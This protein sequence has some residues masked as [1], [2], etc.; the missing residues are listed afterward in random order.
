MAVNTNSL[1]GI[2]KASNAKAISPAVT[3]SA[4]GLNPKTPT[5]PQ[6][7]SKT[8][9]AKPTTTSG[10]ANRFAN[11]AATAAKPAAVTKPAATP[12]KTTATKPAATTKT[13]T[14]VT[15][16][17][18]INTTK[19]G[20]VVPAPKATPGE[21]TPPREGWT[22]DEERGGWIPSPADEGTSVVVSPAETILETPSGER[23]VTRQTDAKAALDA[24]IANILGADWIDFQGSRAAELRRLQNLRNQL[25]GDAA[26]GS[27]GSVQ[28]QQQLDSLARRRLAA[29][30]AS[31]GMLQGGAYAGAQRGL[32][33]IQ[34][35]EQ[36]FNLQELQRP[37][38]EN[39]AADRLA[40]FGLTFDPTGRSFSLSDFGAPGDD[41][42]MMTNWSQRTATGRSA[43]ARARA[44]AIA[45]LAQQGITI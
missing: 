41:Q 11:A 44:A 45:Q 37:F 23:T 5:I 8:P 15:S 34:Q 29:G 20:T 7:I 35:G 12:A 18:P 16:V 36:A 38:Q 25:Y 21:L 1:A 40:E 14:S 33:S 4:L 43:A 31:A 28:R 3:A 30:R 32:G 19:T 17:P 24:A 2:L 10:E 39:V 42:S 13:T 27:T 9:A 26:T 22:W 6:S